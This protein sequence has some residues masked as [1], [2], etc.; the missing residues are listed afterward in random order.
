MTAKAPVKGDL[1]A[2]D[3]DAVSQ[4]NVISNSSNV[5]NLIDNTN[6]SS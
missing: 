2:A 4:L 1:A 5:R 6:S 3:Q